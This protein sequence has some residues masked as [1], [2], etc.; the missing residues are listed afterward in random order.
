MRKQYTFIA[1]YS[2]RLPALNIDLMSHKH[3][4][5]AESLTCY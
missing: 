4:N 1:S 3:W 5:S 2:E